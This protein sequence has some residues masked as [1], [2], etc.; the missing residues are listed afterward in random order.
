MSKVD[1]G[2]NADFFSEFSG[3]QEQQDGFPHGAALTLIPNTNIVEGTKV[4]EAVRAAV[5]AVTARPGDSSGGG[6]PLLADDDSLASAWGLDSLGAVELR[7][8]L[9]AEFGISLSPTLVGDV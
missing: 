8:N 2:P 3:G 4:L 7:N 6:S 9:E 5:S 1:H